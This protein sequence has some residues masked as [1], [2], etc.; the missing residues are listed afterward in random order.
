M[1]LQSQLV[2]H[3]FLS[4]FL[5]R[6]P[7]HLKLILW[8]KNRQNCLPHFHILPPWMKKKWSRPHLSGSTLL[9]SRLQCKPK[10]ALFEFPQK[11]KLRLRNPVELHKKARKHTVVYA[12]A[13]LVIKVVFITWI[14]NLYKCFQ[15]W[16]VCCFT[17]PSASVPLKRYILNQNVQR[18]IITFGNFYKWHKRTGQTTIYKNI[19]QLV[20]NV[21]TVRDVWT[22]WYITL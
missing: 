5:Q 7:F 18:F 1:P 19:S 2:R 3:K 22:F 16:R 10:H 9:S 12:V 20:P 17:S 11:C 14:I 21:R 6:N 13:C 8:G 15:V 4:G